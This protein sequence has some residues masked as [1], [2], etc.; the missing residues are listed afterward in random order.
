MITRIELNIQ[1]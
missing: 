1:A